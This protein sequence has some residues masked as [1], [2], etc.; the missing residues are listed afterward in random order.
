MRKIIGLDKIHEFL[1]YHESLMIGDFE[2]LKNLI[3]TGDSRLVREASRE[4][5]IK[6]SNKL[7]ELDVTVPGCDAKMVLNENPKFLEYYLNNLEFFPRK[8][9]LFQNGSGISTTV[10]R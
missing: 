8:I 9:L 1:F 3:K 4:L 10:V 6:N 7:A 2:N 5:V